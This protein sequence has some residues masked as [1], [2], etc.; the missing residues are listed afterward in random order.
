V[1]KG[2]EAK[3]NKA[4]F[5]ALA[6]RGR[7]TTWDIFKQIKS[8][9]G[10]RYTR[11]ANVNLRVK[12][13]ATSGYVAVTG[14]IKTKSGFLGAVYELTTRAILAMLLNSLDL[15][16]LLLQIDEPTTSE[17]LATVAASTIDNLSI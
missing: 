14:T 15:E 8:Y 9:R 1:F 3:L 10:L 16:D 5:R 13:L 7:L 6:S 11:Y 4:I 2:K 12:A 17:I